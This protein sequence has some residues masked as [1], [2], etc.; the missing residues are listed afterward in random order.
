MDEITES[1]VSIVSADDEYSDNAH[2]VNTQIRAHDS[3]INNRNSNIEIS[4]S[5]SLAIIQ[6]HQKSFM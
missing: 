3:Q 6:K 5:G 2:R 1:I 4:E